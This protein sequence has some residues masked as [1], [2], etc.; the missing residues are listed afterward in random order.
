MNFEKPEATLI[1]EAV[2]QHITLGYTDLG[3]VIG[4]VFS[5]G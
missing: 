4:A 2:T 1:S 5:H 3:N